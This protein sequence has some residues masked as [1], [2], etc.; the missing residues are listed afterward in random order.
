MGRSECEHLD[1]MIGAEC[2]LRDRLLLKNRE[3]NNCSFFK[4]ADLTI[5]KSY[6]HKYLVSVPDVHHFKISNWKDVRVSI[7]I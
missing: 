3:T 5:D 1:L 6:A 7:Y 2:R 4:I